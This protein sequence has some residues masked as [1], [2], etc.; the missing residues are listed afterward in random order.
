MSVSIAMTT[1]NSERFVREQLESFVRQERQP[2]ELVISDD[3]STDRT[4]EILREFALYAPFPVH[5][6]VNERNL[7]VAQN[8]SRAIDRS[9][10]S[11]IFL[12]DADDFWYPQKIFIMEKALTEQPR[13]GLAIC[14]QDLV[15][16]R[17]E[18]LGTTG[19]EFFDR[20]SPSD[21]LLGEIARGETYRPRMPAGSC[22]MAFRAKLKP[23]ILPL[24]GGENSR[25]SSED[26]FIARAIICSG[27][28]GAVLIPRPLLAYRRH[29]A[30]VT[31]AKLTPLLKQ[32]LSRF[33]AAHE[34]PYLL[35]LL[36]ERL[37]SAWAAQQC[38][39]PQIRSLA[40]R[41]WRTRVNMPPS[42]AKRLP[43]VV[44][45]LLALRYHSFSNGAVTVAKDLFFARQRSG[46]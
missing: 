35:P 41:H 40:L 43:I 28:A 19:W 2:D 22:C 38:T 29:P 13:A 6:Y 36:I 8:F 24:P 7:G 25:R 42:F 26:H 33:S 32:I 4:V 16:E 11:I 44:K 27:A 23:L 21:K 45:E 15:N 12:S 34:P 3:A 39:N 31:H 18:P 14:N 37:E 5:I 10:G 46:N 20:F 17:L 30:Q 1:Y 9:T